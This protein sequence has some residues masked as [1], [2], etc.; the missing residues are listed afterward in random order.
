MDETLERE[1]K[2]ISNKQGQICI[3]FNNPKDVNHD[4]IK[5]VNISGEMTFHSIHPIHW[6]HTL[7]RALVLLKESP[8]LLGTILDG[9]PLRHSGTMIE[10]QNL[11]M[12]LQVGDAAHIKT[13]QGWVP[14]V[15]S[16]KLSTPTSYLVT[17]A[18]GRSYCRNMRHL[19]KSPSEPVTILPLPDIGELNTP[20]EEAQST[21]DM[22]PTPPSSAENSTFPQ[23]PS[24]RS[25]RARALPQMLK[26]YVLS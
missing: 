20:L 15:V 23:P 22:S 3:F 9:S 18:N 17:T 24:R 11:L 13:R 14:V 2:T 10:G 25:Q 19:R 8:W 16:S 1:D 21:M 6:D 12:E 5:D 4:G 7:C 26:D